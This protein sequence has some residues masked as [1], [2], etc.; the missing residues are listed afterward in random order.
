MNKN[1]KFLERLLALDRLGARTILKEGNP[2]TPPIQL[3]E[4]LITPVLE[5]IGAGWETGRYSLSQ[6]YMTSR[7]CETLLDEFLPG[8]SPDRIHQPLISIALLEDYHSLGKSIVFAALRA[9]GWELKDYGRCMPDELVARVRDDGTRILLISTLMLR[10]ALRIRE[11]VA[12]LPPEIKI[13]A[14]GAPFR[15]DPGLG[16]ELGVHAVGTTGL[17]AVE[18]VSSLME[19]TA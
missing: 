1:Q 9:G 10:S 4:A 7:M 6:V 17:D 14:G 15:L 19:V 11:I 2:E 8:P 18:I 12:A 16:E 5:E 13:V 3:A